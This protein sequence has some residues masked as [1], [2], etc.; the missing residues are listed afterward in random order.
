MGWQVTCV[1]GGSEE[2]ESENS[3]FGLFPWATEAASCDHPEKREDKGWE[4]E[5]QNPDTSLISGV[6]EYLLFHGKF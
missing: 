5:A 1:F 4:G 6:W 3:H 2:E